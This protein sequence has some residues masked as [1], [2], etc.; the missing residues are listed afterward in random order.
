MY[1]G[2]IRVTLWNQVFYCK[3][4]HILVMRVCAL[5]HICWVVYFTSALGEKTKG[6]ADGGKR[7]EMFYLGLVFLDGQKCG[8]W[9][10]AF[11]FS[12]FF[13]LICSI[14][15]MT[16]TMMF[17]SC[18]CKHTPRI[19]ALSNQQFFKSICTITDTPDLLQLAFDWAVAT[20]LYITVPIDRVYI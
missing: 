1:L 18:R 17:T 7:S 11:S 20:W 12:F 13:F 9:T 5:V 2:L 10:A 3:H 15:K 6:H 16:N 14:N 4:S 8:I 19:Q